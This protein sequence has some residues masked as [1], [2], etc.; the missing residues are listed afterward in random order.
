MSSLTVP[1]RIVVRY[2]SCTLLLLE[3]FCG[4][5][6]SQIKMGDNL[7]VIEQRA[8]LELES[9][10]KGF[11]LPRLTTLQMEGISNFG[12]TPTSRRSIYGMMIFNTDSSC[13]AQYI[14]TA[15]TDRRGWRYLPGG[16]SRIPIRD[17]RNGLRPDSM[18]IVLGGQ[19]DRKTID[20]LNNFNMEW[21]TNGSGNFMI[22]KRTTNKGDTTL[23]VAN[24]GSI[25]IGTSTPAQRLDVVGNVQFSQALM[26]AGNAG[27]SGQ[28][29]IS[30]GANNPPVW[31]DSTQF[32]ADVINKRPAL[33]SLAIALGQSPAKDSLS[34]LLNQGDGFYF[35]ASG[36]TQDIT[37]NMN[38]SRTVADVYNRACLWGNS[39]NIVLNTLSATLSNSDG[40][41]TIG[42]AGLFELYALV[43]LTVT[44]T[45]TTAAT[46]TAGLGVN[47]V[48]VK[49]A[50]GADVN[51]ASN[52]TII[53]GNRMPYVLSNTVSSSMFCSSLAQ[54]NI[55]DR[56]RILCYQG[57][58]SATAPAVS[59]ASLADPG[60][61]PI[62]MMFK[63]TKVVGIR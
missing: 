34:S 63:L 25:G 17:A 27:N 44:F 37:N 26:P 12:T 6:I 4:K 19:L 13:M 14:D 9:K 29:L 56:L 30:R 51:T 5:A 31:K 32:L 43:N 50:A 2:V 58:R 35:T 23:F 24:G 38:A 39:P 20:T 41:I 7:N 18:T 8:L 48:I 28:V 33:D 60:D 61:I 49:C 62:S 57:T 53:A 45:A 11:L 1:Q 42:D 22:R 40:T 46:E 10:N 59:A 21:E 3:L 16:S 36:L 52:W 54:L 15:F 47:T 55:G